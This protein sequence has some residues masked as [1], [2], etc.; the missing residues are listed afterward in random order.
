MLRFVACKADLSYNAVAELQARK[1]QIT[2][3]ERVVSD[4]SIEADGL[5][6]H[7]S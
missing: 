7:L 4:S 5:K 1:M 2:L 3:L 6:V